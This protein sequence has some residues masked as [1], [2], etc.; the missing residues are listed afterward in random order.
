MLLRSTDPL[1]GEFEVFVLDACSDCGLAMQVL[2]GNRLID[3]GEEGKSC[4][5]SGVPSLCRVP[6]WRFPRTE[7]AMA[8][9]SF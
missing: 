9:R 3:H 7:A 6:R 2:E 8:M 4:G 1:P 5:A